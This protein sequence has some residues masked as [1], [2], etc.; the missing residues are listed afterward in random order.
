[1]SSKKIILLLLSM[2]IALVSCTKKEIDVEMSDDP[3]YAA[4]PIKVLSAK[5]G[6]K[7]I[8]GEINNEAHEISFE[9]HAIDDLR[10]IEFRAELEND[11]A[12]MVSPDTIGFQQNLIENNKIVVNDGVDDITYDLKASIYQL[13][14]GASATVLSEKSEAEVAGNIISLKF[15][16]VYDPS[17]FSSFSLDL[18]L[19]E[20]AELVSPATL[21]SMD[22][23]DGSETIII[24][25]KISG[26]QRNYTLIVSTGDLINVSA[27]W[28][29]ITT[30]LMSEKQLGLSTAIK[31]YKIDNL[32]GFKDNVAYAFAI[33]A[34]KVGLKVIEKNM[35]PDCRMS[36]VVRANR[37]YSIFLSLQGHNAWGQDSNHKEYFSP[38]AYG[39]DASGEKKVLRTDGW[40]G[41]MKSYSPALAVKDGVVAMANASA[42]KSTGE[43]DRYN[44]VKGNGAADW[45]E[46]DAAF[47]GYFQI[48]KSGQILISSEGRDA[49]EAFSKD[50]RR[51][52]LKSFQT[53]SWKYD[54]V[55][56][57][58]ALRTGR[59]GVGCTAKGD[60]VL[61]M[62]DKQYNTHNQGQGRDSKH[63][64]ALSESEKLN[65]E[66]QFIPD[67]KGVTLFE[68]AAV[69][70]DLGCSEVMTVEDYSWSFI[71]LQD[72]QE[73][74]YDLVKT[75]SRYSFKTGERK[76]E[77]S[78]YENMIIV[79]IK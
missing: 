42:D 21:E 9:F 30:S 45:S 29:D 34:G 55:W 15:D 20:G 69:M 78:E 73:R 26:V 77:T 17:D 10:N 54:P 76:A 53:P 63:Q 43:F 50:N 7:W 31:I 49:Y 71:T 35:V 11:W 59:I 39:P 16:T 14:F 4:N 27:G 44:D 37:D 57:H 67:E 58:D 18:K 1:M 8:L 51:P 75:N 5:D 25:D 68:L 19:N 28:K 61:F 48:V 62:S 2:S 66:S 74:G 47:G 56:Y 79:C 3:G 52:D 22:L 32:N 33:P 64:G 36:P 70:A 46:V 12:V 72:G 13:V 41:K 60:L 40:N 6:D 38:L 23:S 65:K 24:K